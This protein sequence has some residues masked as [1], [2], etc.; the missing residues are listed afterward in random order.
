M[1]RVFG[2]THTKAMSRIAMTLV[3]CIRREERRRHDAVFLCHDDERSAD[4]LAVGFKDLLSS[5][6]FPMRRSVNEIFQRDERNR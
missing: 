6:I 1:L 3:A 5:P 2:Q 4:D